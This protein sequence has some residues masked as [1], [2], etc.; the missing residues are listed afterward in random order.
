MS[1][2]ATKPRVRNAAST[3]QTLED[4]FIRGRDL[5]IELM[6]DACARRDDA[7]LQDARECRR[8]MREGNAQDNFVADYLNDV[9]KD[10]SLIA[11]FSAI[12]STALD[13]DGCSLDDLRPITLAETQDGEVG[14]DGTEPYPPYFHE[15]APSLEIA[16]PDRGQ[17]LDDAI[18]HYVRALAVVRKCCYDG[19]L[20]GLVF[21]ARD[22][23]DHEKE[24]LYKASSDS[25]AIELQLSSA[26]QWTLLELL[27]AAA[28][29]VDDIDDQALMWGA[30]TLAELCKDKLDAYIGVGGEG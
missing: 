30:H 3:D 7:A 24:R 22:L 11:G 25:D 8:W 9:I 21:A 29:A 27:K 5:A 10:R 18:G 6:K 12:L 23:M 2:V 16:S 28:H 4:D 15:P 20:C 26:S 17:L 19:Q 1:A 14:S 13:N